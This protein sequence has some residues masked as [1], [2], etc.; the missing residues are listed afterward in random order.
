MRKKIFFSAAALLS[1][2]SLLA[3]VEKGQLYGDVSFGKKVL[4]FSTTT[5]QPSFSIG[6]SE[7]S[8]LGVFYNYTRSKSTPTISSNGYFISQ[9]F[10]V[11]YNYYHF[12]KKSQQWGW[13]FNGSFSANQTSVYDK[14]GGVLL[15]NN[16]Y[17]ERELSFTPGI[18]FKPSK[19]VMLFANIGGISLANNRYDF[20]VPRSS[21]ASQLNLGI[22]I[23]IGGNKGKKNRTP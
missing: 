9:G 2:Y 17:A 21:F 16:R 13:Y 18:F 11:S 20:I 14:A 12:F 15:L 3:Q 1:C 7:H 4:K 19:G 8:T 5:I 6:L 23:N 22:R 10:G